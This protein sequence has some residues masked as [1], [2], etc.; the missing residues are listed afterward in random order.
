MISILA[1]PSPCR[2]EPLA[3]LCF[4]SED[5]FTRQQI[6]KWRF[7]LNRGGTIP[8]LAWSRTPGRALHS[9]EKT[10][11]FFH[12]SSAALVS[13]QQGNQSPDPALVLA[14]QRDYAQ[15]LSP[16][17]RGTSRSTSPFA[18]IRDPW[19]N[20]WANA[21]VIQLIFSFNS[22]LVQWRLRKLWRTGK[23]RY[24]QGVP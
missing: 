15:H 10:A 4:H 20:M 23:D 18:I 1:I 16:H 6:F 21:G 22:G 9:T 19:C 2:P 12:R 14:K 7:P 8:A 3:G 11:S 5:H 17:S 24:S 13:A